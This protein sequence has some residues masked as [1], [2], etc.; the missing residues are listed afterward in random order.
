MSVRCVSCCQQSMLAWLGECARIPDRLACVLATT[1]CLQA[2]RRNSSATVGHKR[3]GASVA[4]AGGSQKRR[5]ARATATKISYAGE[6]HAAGRYRCFSGTHSSVSTF[7][8]ES[9][10][11]LGP[12]WCCLH[13]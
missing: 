10:V 11:G 13:A 9:A 12:T 3:G 1:C 4:T 2:S 6:R 7:A 8:L 5:C